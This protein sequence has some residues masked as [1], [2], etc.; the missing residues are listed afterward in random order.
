MVI[1]KHGRYIK[2]REETPLWNLLVGMLE[3]VDAET[4]Q[5]AD[6]TGAF[7]AERHQLLAGSRQR[8]TAVGYGS[9]GLLT[10]PIDSKPHL[11]SGP[12]VDRWLLPKPYAGRG[13]GRNDI[14]RMQ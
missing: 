14:A 3:A 11:L 8:L 4:S 6:S 1:L 9:L 10:E 5:F 13:S 12:E 7:A 2:M